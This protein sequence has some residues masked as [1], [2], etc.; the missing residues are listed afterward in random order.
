MVKKEEK[1]HAIFYTMSEWYTLKQKIY[2]NLLQ[3]SDG[4]IIDMYTI[5]MITGSILTLT[6]NIFFVNKHTIN[7]KIV[8]KKTK[9][10]IFGKDFFIFNSQCKYF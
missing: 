9:K 1:T 8:C 2:Q 3:D 5:E 6:S 4:V 7:L 10:K